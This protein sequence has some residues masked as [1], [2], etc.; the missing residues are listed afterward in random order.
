MP[1][2]SYLGLRLGLCTAVG[3]CACGAFYSADTVCD[4]SV[5]Y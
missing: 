1:S 2:P 4:R 5:N 3:F